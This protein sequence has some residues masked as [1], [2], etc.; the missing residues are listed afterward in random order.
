MKFIL[1]MYIMILL[2]FIMGSGVAMAAPSVG[3]PSDNKIEFEIL[4]GGKPFGTH[5]ISFN[6]NGDVVQ[7]DIKIQM[8]YK[9]LGLTAFRYDHTNSETW[10]GNKLLSVKS[11]TD[12][13]GRKYSVDKENLNGI[14]SSSYWNQKSISKSKI[15]NTQYGTM[16]DIK[17]TKAKSQTLTIAGKTIKADVY[18]VNTTVPIT[19]MYD[20]K[21][22]QWVG[23]TFTA[24][25]ATVEYRRK[26]PL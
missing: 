7:S 1:P 12:D 21:T 2:C 8:R 10:K 24:R 4:R 6:R 18:N 15:L 23:L 20:Q 25:G 5:E 17:V 3:I 13:D 16:D 26:D 19:V 11:S 14:Y 9:L 22:K